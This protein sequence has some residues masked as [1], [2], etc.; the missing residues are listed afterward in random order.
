M[1]GLDLEAV[2]RIVVQMDERGMWSPEYRLCKADNKPVLL[3]QGAFSYVYQIYDVHTPQKRYAA[4]F[5]GFGEEKINH[6]LI[7]DSTQI[8]YFLGEQCDNII[9][10]IDLWNIVISLDDNG[11]IVTD[12]NSSQYEILIDVIIMEYM[13]CVI[14]HDRYGNT[15]LIR[16]TLKTEKEV[17]NFAK[18]IGN[19]LVTVHENGYLHRDIK[20]ENFFF[21]HDLQLYKLGDFNI[22][23]YIGG[24]TAETVVF[25][26]GYGAPEI[27]KHLRESYN[28]T[29]DIYSFGITLYLLLNDLKFPASD[30]YYVNTEQQYS[31]E[32]ILPAPKNASV[33]IT[34]IIQK[35]TSYNPEERYQSID[36]VLI[37]IDKI[38]DDYREDG[39]AIT[40]DEVTETYREQDKTTDKVISKGVG[41]LREEMKRQEQLKTEEAIK[42]NIKNCILTSI[43][44][45]ILSKLCFLDSDYVEC[46]QFWML[47]AAL[48]CESL[49]QRRKEF[50]ITFGIVVFGVAI[51]T[52]YLFGIHVPHI[53]M[54]LIMLFGNPAITEGCAIGTVLAI[55]VEI[56]MRILG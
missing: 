37:D 53:V 26:N 47:P 2:N 29:A 35:M 43:A 14:A 38:A 3:G 6:E 54:L 41:L 24:G 15:E 42:K 55:V 49:F 28:V 5:M 56:I 7:S 20:L 18:Q 30:G 27:E 33:G 40:D 32:F 44:V 16:D 11:N 12:K 39:L 13:E 52:V 34:K 8:Q 21:N 22:T 1:L 4:K 46:W 36:E 17:L 23:R 19:A 48:F 51:Y 45:F 50:H 31:K 10:V 9:R 25:T